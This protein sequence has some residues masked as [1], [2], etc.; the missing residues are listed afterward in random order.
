MASIDEHGVHILGLRVS[1]LLLQ[2]KVLLLALLHILLGCRQEHA[3][4][5]VLHIGEL[6]SPAEGAWP[7]APKFVMMS[8]LTKGIMMRDHS[9]ALYLTPI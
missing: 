4:V 1:R 8:R 9:L 7:R 6:V 3:L 2:P 5:V